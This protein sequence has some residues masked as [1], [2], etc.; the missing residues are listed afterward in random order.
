MDG[1][2][3]PT[4]GLLHAETA[5][6]RLCEIEGKG[7]A[8]VSRALRATRARGDEE[9][10]ET[11]ARAQG[12]RVGSRAAA[13]RSRHRASV[14]PAFG[15]GVGVE[16]YRGSET[17]L[18]EQTTLGQEL[19]DVGG[20]HDVPVD[21]GRGGSEVS[22]DPISKGYA[23]GTLRDPEARARGKRAGED[24]ATRADRHARARTRVSRVSS[25][26]RD[27]DIA[28]GIAVVPV[29]GSFE[30]G[31]PATSRANSVRR[32]QQI[33]QRIEARGKTSRADARVP[34]LV[35]VVV[36]LLGVLNL[37]HVLLSSRCRVGRAERSGREPGDATLSL[38][39][40]F[41]ARA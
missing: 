30:A 39:R 19:G 6:L 34:V 36:V 2:V 10:R 28:R 35:D 17:Y 40:S 20:K 3:H 33:K 41:R 1:V 18:G 7:E 14:S 29:A 37:R 11:P 27:S 15:R 26:A 23:A 38:K 16:P 4:A 24:V 12:E 9:S 25:T 5:P 13:M 8:R 31:E 32:V 21:G 22:G